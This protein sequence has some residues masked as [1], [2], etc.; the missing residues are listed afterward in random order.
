MEVSGTKQK[1]NQ[2]NSRN[3]K[4]AMKKNS[5]AIWSGSYQESKLSKIGFNMGLIKKYQ[6]ARILE[7]SGKQ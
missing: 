1:P 3:Y 7:G 2:K 5:I 6:Q 4:E